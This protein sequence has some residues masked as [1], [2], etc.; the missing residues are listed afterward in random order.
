MHSHTKKSSFCRL[1]RRIGVELFRASFKSN[2]Q[3]PD[4]KC[5]ISGA[6]NCYIIL[7]GFF[8]NIDILDMYL[9]TNKNE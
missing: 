5:I 6:N 3:L 2:F 7:S 9:M 1:W 8:N 4:K